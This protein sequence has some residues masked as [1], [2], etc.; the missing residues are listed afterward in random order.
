MRARA[1]RLRDEG[2]GERDAIDGQDV[3]VASGRRLRI[4]KGPIMILIVEQE[5][6]K[7]KEGGVRGA[8]AVTDRGL[9][10]STLR[11]TCILTGEKIVVGR[12]AQEL[13]GERLVKEKMQGQTRECGLCDLSLMSNFGGKVVKA[14]IQQ[15]R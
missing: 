6:G 5:R 7:R 1:R 14:C 4:R 8:T 9:K 2:S 15:C 12:H 10:L 11:R 3:V 13:C